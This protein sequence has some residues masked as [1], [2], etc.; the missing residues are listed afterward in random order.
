MHEFLHFTRA[1]EFAFYPP[2]IHQLTSVGDSGSNKSVSD[3]EEYFIMLD[4]PTIE[5]LTLCIETLQNSKKASPTL[6]R[7]TKVLQSSAGLQRYELSTDFYRVTKE[8]LMA[9]QKRRSVL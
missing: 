2:Y 1:L 4:T 6:D 7:D 9:E 8:D 3:G 5:H